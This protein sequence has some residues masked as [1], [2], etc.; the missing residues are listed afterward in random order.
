MNIF[1]QSM[2]A[3][4][5]LFININW[6]KTQ[7]VVTNLRIELGIGTAGHSVWSN[8]NTWEYLCSQVDMD[9][10]IDWMIMESYSTNTDTQQNLRYFRSSELGGR[11][12]FCYYDIDWGWHYNAQFSHVL[13]SNF[14]WQH[15]GIT[16]NFTENAEF[17]QRLL[18]RLSDLLDTTLSNENVLARIEYYAQLLEPEV[19]R[20]RDRWGSSY[21]AWEGRVQELRDFLADGHLKKMI[22]SLDRFIG[23]TKEEKETYFGRWLN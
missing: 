3:A 5:L 22:T 11:W 17:R 14:S 6:C 4:M 20:E 18:A 16:K 2:N 21:A 12:M 7:T 9:S 8:A 1:I 19:S 23:L 10:I 13:S 15:M